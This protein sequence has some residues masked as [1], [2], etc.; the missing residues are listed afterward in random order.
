MHRVARRLGRLG[1][2]FDSQLRLQRE[3]FSPALPGQPQ[4][5]PSTVSIG[6]MYSLGP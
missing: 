6:G 4:Q 5:R 1:A 3:L 2:R